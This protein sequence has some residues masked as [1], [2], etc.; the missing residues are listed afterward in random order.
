[1]EFIELLPRKKNLPRLKKFIPSFLGSLLAVISLTC[2]SL[3]LLGNWLVRED[4]IREA[5]AIVVLSG[6]FPQ[7]ALEAAALYRRGYAPE[8]WLTHPMNNRKP[9]APGKL[10][11]PSEDERNLEVLRSFGVP[12]D[13]IRV[14]APPIV[15]TADELNAIGSYLQESGNVS[16]IVVTD[17]L[18]TRRVYALWTK[19]HSDDGEI[20]I[21]AVSQD[22]FEPSR[23][24]RLPSTRTQGVHELLGMV[25]V[26][27]GM[28]V[29]R[30]LQTT[31]SAGSV[32]EPPLPDDPTSE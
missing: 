18:H 28:P 32:A 14:L 19:Y 6:R 20:L 4:P 5:D 3:P 15:N 23:W 26:W 16:A 2:F 25:N 29:H 17:E 10:P 1:M 21:H 11:S 30:P 24:W 8:V 9:D 7:R 27:A 22:E 12:Q 13:A 31:A